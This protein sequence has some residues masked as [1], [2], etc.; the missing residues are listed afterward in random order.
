MIRPDGA[1]GILPVEEALV[2]EVI[3]EGQR[4]IIRYTGR[5]LEIGS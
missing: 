2:V 4:Q 5:P 3:H 1:A